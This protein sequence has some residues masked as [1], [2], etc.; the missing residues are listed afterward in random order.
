MG[1]VARIVPT[2]CVRGRP[3]SAQSLLGKGIKNFLSRGVWSS[4]LLHEWCR[5]AGRWAGHLC[6]AVFPSAR[7]APSFLRLPTGR[8]R[9]RRP[10][11]VSSLLT[12]RSLPKGRPVCVR[13]RI[14]ATSS[15]V[16]PSANSLR[17][18]AAEICLYQRRRFN[19]SDS[20]FSSVWRAALDQGYCHARRHSFART[21]LNSTYLS[22]G[23]P[24]HRNRTVPATDGRCAGG[25]G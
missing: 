21:G 11:T 22:A 25:A 19:S 18:A 4:Q 8:G 15:S 5:L 17:H 3:K 6:P 10:S 9:T 1:R 23:H 16:N 7:P 2:F 13:S 12:K 14:R 20:A 24:G